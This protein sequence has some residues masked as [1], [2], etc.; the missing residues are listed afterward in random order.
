MEL[1]KKEKLVL[2]EI[3]IKEGSGVFLVE[4]GDKNRAI[5]V[6]YHKPENYRSDSKVL[7]VIPGAGRNGDSY[8][9]AWVEKSEKYSILI[10]S[11]RYAEKDFGFGDYHM[12]GL[13]YDLDLENSVSYIENSNVAEL[14][15]GNFAFK[16]NSNSDEWIFN[17]FDRILDLVASS[18]QSTETQYD[19]FGHSA[20][21]QILHRLAIFQKASKANHILAANSGFYTLPDVEVNLP[22]GI[23]DAPIEDQDLQLS[24]AKKLVLL[25]GELDNESETGGTLLRSPTV[26][27]QG[28]N[29]LDRGKFFFNQS[30][31]LANALGFEFNWEL[32]II[33]NVGHD[34][35]KMGDAAAAYLYGNAK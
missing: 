4:A 20:G 3:N 23:K 35:R 2:N 19:I 27:K 1:I 22:F 13:I 32:Q 12:S 5:E 31:S 6:Y 17:D 15:E 34:H 25:V 28:L 30:R 8:R 33:P 11:P 10:L 24:F 18:L 9:D 16:V 21:G 14:N 29:R 26:D 7:L